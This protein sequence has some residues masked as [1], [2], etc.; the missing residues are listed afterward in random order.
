MYSCKAKRANRLSSGGVERWVP[1]TLI[2][3]DLD[4]ALALP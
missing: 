3:G 1:A 2:T 4:G